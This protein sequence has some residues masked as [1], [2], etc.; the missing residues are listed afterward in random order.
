MWRIGHLVSTL[1]NC[2]TIIVIGNHIF[3]WITHILLLS[4]RYNV[5]YEKTREVIGQFQSNF[6]F[7]RI[8]I[9]NYRLFFFSLSPDRLLHARLPNGIHP[10]RGLP[11]AWLIQVDK[12]HSRSTV[13]YEDF[14]QST[15]LNPS[16]D[17]KPEARVTSWFISGIRNDLSNLIYFCHANNS[18]IWIR[19]NRNYQQENCPPGLA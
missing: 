12:S 14:I 5:N 7:V 16:R 17:N 1:P 6:R 10:Q 19:Q 9:M 11:M 15:Q 3:D 8:L 2:L 4:G 18:Q 13:K